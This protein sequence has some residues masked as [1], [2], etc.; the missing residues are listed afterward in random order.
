[1]QTVSMFVAA[2]PV[3]HLLTDIGIA[4]IAATVIGLAAHWLRQPILLGYII[5]GA[6]IGPIGF[7][8]IK[9]EHS[10]E[11]ISEIGLVL[12]LFI[13]GLEL[14]IGQILRAGKQLLVSGF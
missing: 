1:M 4:V 11:T 7:N 5:A 3:H 14:N 6:L 10:I 12:L 9:G 2:A 8:W 13:I